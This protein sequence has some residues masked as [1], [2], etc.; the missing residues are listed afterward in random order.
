MLDI[1]MLFM[2]KTISQWKLTQ[3]CI[4][5][6]LQKKRREIHFPIKKCA[7]EE[8]IGSAQYPPILILTL[9]SK[10]IDTLIRKVHWYQSTLNY[11]NM[12][13]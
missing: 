7:I 13:D 12:Q 1:K 11:V 3:K 9:I 6:W 4:L 8:K 2:K 10:Y 5:S